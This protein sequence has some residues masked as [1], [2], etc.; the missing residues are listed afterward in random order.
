[1]IYSLLFSSYTF[2]FQDL[3]LLTSRIS[4]CH[5]VLRAECWRP[6]RPAPSLASSYHNT[7]INQARRQN[8]T[9]FNADFPDRDTILL[10]PF[11]PTAVP[12]SHRSTPCDPFLT[13]RTF[14]SAENARHVPV[15]ISFDEALAVTA[16]LPPL[17]SAPGTL[18]KE[19]APPPAVRRWPY[20]RRQSLFTYS[21]TLHFT[22]R[23]PLLSKSP[24]KENNS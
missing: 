16:Y 3:A 17:G 14:H 22:S 10:Y 21:T 7:R 15:R 20:G 8:R 23:P 13:M 4:P 19:R 1:M 9:H 18:V 5:H 2:P 24:G 11:T 12:I 6:G